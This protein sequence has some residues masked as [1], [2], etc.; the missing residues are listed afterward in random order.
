[1]SVYVF[2]KINKTHLGI[3]QMNKKKN[4]NVS[5]INKLEVENNKRKLAK[6]VELISI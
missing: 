1:M 3:L 2:L 5:I 4:I 6:C